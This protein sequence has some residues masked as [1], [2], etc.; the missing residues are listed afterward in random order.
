M[1]IYWDAVMKKLSIA[2]LVRCHPI[3]PFEKPGKIAAIV[4]SRFV[5][6]HLDG[7]ITGGKQLGGFFQSQLL[8]NLPRCF[9]I[10]FFQEADYI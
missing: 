9:L 6:Y 2:P 10:A 7:G 5:R 1:S 8:N 3:V 4:K